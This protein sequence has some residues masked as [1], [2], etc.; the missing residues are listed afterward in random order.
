MPFDWLKA[1]GL[2]QRFLSNSQLR[3]MLI[4]LRKRIIT[5][6]PT[7]VWGERCVRALHVC[8]ILLAA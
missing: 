7:I 1:N 2:N 4:H 6:T 8:D 3:G 5:S